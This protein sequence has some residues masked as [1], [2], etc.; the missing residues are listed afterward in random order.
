MAG[1]D[2]S[3]HNRSD[4]GRYDEY[5]GFE[6]YS[7]DRYVSFEDDEDRVIQALRDNTDDGW[8][9][10]GEE[11][12]DE[13]EGYYEDEE[14]YDEE[15]YYEDD[16]YY[17]DD[18]Y[19]EEPE[20]RYPAA[21]GRRK[22]SG[23]GHP[24]KKKARPVKHPAGGRG[25]NGRLE[26][27]KKKR[28][29]L[30]VLEIFIFLALLIAL[31]VMMKWSKVNKEE[32]T[33]SQFYS[34]EEIKAAL[35]STPEEIEDSGGSA[36]WGMKGYKNVA[37]FGVDAGG[38]RSDTIIIASINTKT[39][40]VKMCSVYRDTYLNVDSMENPVYNKANSAYSK[41]GPEQAIR[42]LNMNLDM[43]VDD[44]V[45]VDFDAL[46]DIIDD[47]GGVEINVQPEEVDYINDYQFS[48]VM[49]LGGPNEGKIKNSRHVIAVSVPR[50]QTLCSFPAS[51]Y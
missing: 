49:D 1:R 37:L 20:G 10:D 32:L 9:E 6:K 27:K 3:G 17:E 34:N 23:G 29:W 21:S 40:E 11:Y 48:I 46:E 38:T 28:I 14:Y 50:L 35:D 12:Y 39:Y 15:E 36:D 33:E 42:M 8:Y 16:G 24:K 43:N 26:P 41:G 2:R 51:A 19:E 7:R 5:N 4:E 18:Y 13:D 31:F 47:L 30:F 45:T 25:K 22:S 44:F